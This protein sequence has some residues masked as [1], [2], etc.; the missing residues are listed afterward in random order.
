MWQLQC[1]PFAL[2][3]EERHGT[4][5]KDSDIMHEIY[6]IKIGFK[7]ANDAYSPVKLADFW[8][9]LGNKSYSYQKN[10]RQSRRC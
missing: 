5:D 1:P 6:N 4:Y 2:G 10:Q 7:Y 8:P 3:I 9:V